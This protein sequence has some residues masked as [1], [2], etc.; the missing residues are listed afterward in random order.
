MTNITQ[1]KPNKFIK[2][3]LW[4]SYL[5]LAGGVLLLIWLIQHI[6]TE[7]ILDYLKKLGWNFI[8]FLSISFFT[9][10]FFTFSWNAFLKGHHYQ[11]KFWRL[12][13]LKT[14][15]EA[16][17]TMNPLGFGGGDPVRI[18][19]MKKDI[20][21]AESTASVVVDRTLNSIAL[22]VFML[23]GIL[24]AFIKFD[25]PRPLQIGFPLSLLFIFWMT[26]YWY[27]RQHEGVFQF[28][29]EC[30]IKLKIKKKWPEETLQKLKEID[31]YITDFYKHNKKGF[32]FAL[33]LQMICRILG[34]LEI[35]L[36][37]Y[38]LGF[39]MDF[40]SAYLLASVTVIINLIFVF[41]PGSV[42]VMEGAYAGIFM[43]TH[44]DPAIGT[45]IGILRRI[46]VLLWSAVGL[47][48]IYHQ[49]R[50]TR[51]QLKKLSLEI[52]E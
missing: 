49:D 33:N 29:V 10:I 19:L 3:S 23:I 26:Y 17:N 5:L 18:F 39:S 21:V 15:G 46:R 51:L 22:V 9:F 8:P 13:M 27:K 28:L 48:Y 47:Y 38:Y 7:L 20:P 43:L 50:R 41:I 4:I 2:H 30:L 40:I 11:M 36:A 31:R 32:Y 6:G 37:A 52:D 44:Q 1:K 16:V 34:V 12:F 25:L 14:T 35:Y 42:G 45:S 24:I